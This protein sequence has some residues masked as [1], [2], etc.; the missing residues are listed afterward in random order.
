MHESCAIGTA[1]VAVQAFFLSSLFE[2][3]VQHLPG[4]RRRGATAGFAVLDDDA[5]SDFRVLVRREAGGPGGGA[6]LSVL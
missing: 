3:V 2:P 1:F 5:D 6:L 4:D